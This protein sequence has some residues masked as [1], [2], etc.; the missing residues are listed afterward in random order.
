MF[1]RCVLLRMKKKEGCFSGQLFCRRCQPEDRQSGAGTVDA[2]QKSAR[3]PSRIQGKVARAA[4]HRF[5][6][7]T[8]DEQN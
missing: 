4:K 5:L 2:S 1:F 8:E 6:A 7:E 3:I